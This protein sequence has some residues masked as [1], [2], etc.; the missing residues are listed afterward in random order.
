MDIRNGAKEGVRTSQ[1]KAFLNSFTSIKPSALFISLIFLNA[2]YN[3]SI[4]ET[5]TKGPDEGGQEKG[6]AKAEVTED[7]INNKYRDFKKEL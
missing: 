4:S 5:A 3:S 2:S 6:G 7:S 1:P